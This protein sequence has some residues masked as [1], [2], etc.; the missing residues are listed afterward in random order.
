MENAF[1]DAANSTSGVFDFNCGPGANGCFGAMGTLR[2]VLG[3]LL[4]IRTGTGRGAGWEEGVRGR[5]REK[6]D[7]VKRTQTKQTNK[8]TDRQADGHTDGQTDTYTHT[9]THSLTHSHTDSLT[10]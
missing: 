1:E 5:V 6:R 7:R 3:A 8:Q 9:H 2:V 10:H 4:F